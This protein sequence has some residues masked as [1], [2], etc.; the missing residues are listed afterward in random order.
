MKKS[1]AS[2]ASVSVLASTLLS[3]IAPAQAFPL[4]GGYP[5]PVGSNVRDHRGPGP[6]IRDHRPPK[7]LETT[8]NQGGVTVTVSSWPRPDVRDH[9]RGRCTHF[10]NGSYHQRPIC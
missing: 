8:K 2:L 6:V 7:R 1:L 9:R 4:N 10:Y 5:S 3:T